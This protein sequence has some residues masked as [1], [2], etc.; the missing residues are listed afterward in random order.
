MIFRKNEKLAVKSSA[1]QVEGI[2][3]TPFHVWQEIFK[4]L[5]DYSESINRQKLANYDK[6]LLP[7]LNVLSFVWFHETEK[8]KSMSVQVRFEQTQTLLLKIL[9]DQIPPHSLIVIQN[10]QW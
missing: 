2:F 1:S 3:R 7:L 8:T 6:D 5:L 10:I 4:D 9:T